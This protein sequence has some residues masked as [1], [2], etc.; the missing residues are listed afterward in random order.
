MKSSSAARSGVSRRGFIAGGAA[1]L[2]GAAGGVLGSAS[3]ANAA[4]SYAKVPKLPGEVSRTSDLRTK[5]GT[6]YE[7]IDVSILGD[8]ARIFVPHSAPPNKYAWVPVVWFYHANNSS[9]TSLSS[10][11]LYGAEPAVDKGA[12][13]VCPDYAGATAW[14]SAP[15]VRAQT[16][17]V[18]YM[19]SLWRIY[20]SFGRSNS[21]GGALM[22]WAFGN[23][24]LPRQQGMYLASSV[25]DMMDV[26]TRGPSRV[27]PA[28]GYDLEA[29]QATNPATLPQSSWTGSRIRASFN[30]DDQTVP[31]QQ[32]AIALLTLAQPVAV[33]TSY[34]THD[35]G[36]TA[37]GHTVPGWVH[38]DMLKAFQ[39]WANL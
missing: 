33:E 8:M 4:V 36:G 27:G 37:T 18:A 12:I 7:S 13:A 16:N 25:Y 10:A 30:P 3:V 35:G 17:A 6:L 19:N 26:Y 1:A 21:G 14:V 5:A 32:H 31:P 15:A 34:I 23:N 29:I 2:L 20:Y 9:Y 38:T 11:F 24:L 39:R 28:Y 22:C